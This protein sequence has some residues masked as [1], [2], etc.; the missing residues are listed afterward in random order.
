MLTMERNQLQVGT[1]LLCYDEVLSF[2]LGEEYEITK[3]D[4][5]GYHV[6]IGHGLTI[7]FGT[8]NALKAVFMIE[9]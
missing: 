3:V 7:I 9:E 2:K 1:K 6:G 5:H 4:E 8:I